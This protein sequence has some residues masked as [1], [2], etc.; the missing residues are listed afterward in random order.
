MPTPATTMSALEDESPL[1]TFFLAREEFHSRPNSLDLE[2]HTVTPSQT[3][4]PADDLKNLFHKIDQ[5]EAEI[6]RLQGLLAI[7]GLAANREKPSKPKRWYAVRVAIP[8]ALA[9]TIS[10]FTVTYIF[11]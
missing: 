1:E 6:K 11:L 3:T 5:A 9:I 8:Y 2:T 4:Y 7:A 10:V